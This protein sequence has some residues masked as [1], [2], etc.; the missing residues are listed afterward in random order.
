MYQQLMDYE[1]TIFENENSPSLP[2]TVSS[3]AESIL[4]DALQELSV[5]TTETRSTSVAHL[6]V[7]PPNVCTDGA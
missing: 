3:S 1:Q 6:A 4:K 2:G 5:G 7:N